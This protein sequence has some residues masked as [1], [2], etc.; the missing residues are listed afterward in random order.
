[1]VKKALK[2]KP[3]GLNTLKSSASPH[4]LLNKY[5]TQPK[6]QYSRQYPKFRLK[7]KCLFI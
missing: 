2:P 7:A 1:M 4:H 5:L 6:H 3:F